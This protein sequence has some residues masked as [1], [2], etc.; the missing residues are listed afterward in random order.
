M[1]TDTGTHTGIHTDTHTEAHT[2]IQRHTHTPW[3]LVMNYAE[4]HSV[5]HHM[6][7][8]RTWSYVGF[9]SDCM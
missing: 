4:V 9:L 3:T 8:M 6:A 2:H 7:Y 1:H 5:E